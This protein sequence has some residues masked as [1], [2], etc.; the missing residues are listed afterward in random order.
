[1]RKVLI[2]SAV[3]MFLFLMALGCSSSSKNPG[4]PDLPELSKPS[5]NATSSDTQ[6]LCSG[7]MN[8]ENGKVDFN[9]RTVDPYL[10][11]TS[12]VGSNFHFKIDSFTPP[13]ILNITLTL[14]NVST[15]TA[16]DVAIVFE[17]LYGKKVLNPDSYIDIF[18]AG[19]I[20]PF[21]AFRK[22]DPMRA[23]PPGPDSQPL[24]VKYNGNPN[25]KFFIIAHIPGNTGGVY[26][27]SHWRYSGQLTSN[28]GSAEIFVDVYD[29]QDDISYVIADTRAL[30]GSTTPLIR[31]TPPNPWSAIISNTKGIPAGTYPLLIASTSFASPTY[32]TY[33]FFPII[34][35]PGMTNFGVDFSPEGDTELLIREMYSSGMHSI[36]S[37]GN[38]FYVVFDAFSPLSGAGAVYFTKSTDGGATWS[39]AK[40]VSD[41]LD[42]QMEK[43]ACIAVGNGN[44]YVACLGG[45]FDKNSF[46]VSS[47]DGDTW[48]GY[49]PF[50]PIGFPLNYVSLCVDPTTTPETVYLGFIYFSPDGMVCKA[51]KATTDDFATWSFAQIIDEIAPQGQFD[52][53]LAFDKETDHLLACWAGISK[54]P[55]GGS[56]ILFD[57]ASTSDFTTWHTDTAVSD[58]WTIGDQELN[59]SPAIDPATGKLGILYKK[60]LS[61]YSSMEVR[62]LVVDHSVDPITATPSVTVYSTTQDLQN[63]SLTWNAASGRV[64]AS[65]S[66]GADAAQLDCYFSESTD[67]GLSWVNLQTLN[68]VPAPI[69]L[70]NTTIASSGHDVNVAWIDGRVHGPELWIDQGKY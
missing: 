28:G 52:L 18:G 6:V 14:N 44:I 7:T 30:M 62:F 33:N 61:D 16:Y 63:P 12:L 20:D 58:N 45:S 47:D 51:G 19:D 67:K 23:F 70:T 11:V 43:N 69:G 26:E 68:D 46:F 53:S 55:M 66:A 42:D 27:I 65:W 10:N 39:T 35:V 2:L 34:I 5:D 8:L 13:D 57:W 31:L 56:Q 37:K 54:G 50:T 29:H 17:E 48:T 64:F 1:M 59:P 60:I 36:A 21:I 32:T 25:V 22:A 3:F 38:E 40:A 49:A 9:D 15:L 41:P 24:T 4:V